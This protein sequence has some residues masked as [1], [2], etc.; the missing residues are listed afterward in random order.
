V[1]ES[2]RAPPG[3]HRA[4]GARR[5]PGGRGRPA[6]HRGTPIARSRIGRIPPARWI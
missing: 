6:P 1:P 3:S 4:P 5:R 2:Y